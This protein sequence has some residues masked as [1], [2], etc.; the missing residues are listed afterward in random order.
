LDLP[1]KERWNLQLI[2]LTE[3]NV[4]ADWQAAMFVELSTA[5]RVDLRFLAGHA[6]LLALPAGAAWARAAALG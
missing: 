5:R 4:P 1:A 3:S 6:A 2:V